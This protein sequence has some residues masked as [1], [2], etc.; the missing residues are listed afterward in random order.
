MRQIASIPGLSPDRYLVVD[1]HDTA[2]LCLQWLRD[3]IVD[4]RRRPCVETGGHARSRYRADLDAPGRRAR[5]RREAAAS[6]S[7]RGWPASAPRSPI[8]T[9]GGGFHNLSLATT[10]AHLVRAVLEGV[11]YNSRW[12]YEAVGAFVKRRL[13]PLRVIGGG[14]HRTC[15]ARSTPTSWTARSSGWPNPC[16]PTCG[17]RR[18]SPAWRSASV[19][20]EE[21]RALVAGRRASSPTQPTAA[22]YD[23]LYAE[24][25]RLYRAQK[26]MFARL[27]RR[28]AI[29]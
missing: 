29:T 1:N 26:P 20:A 14:A 12:L 18:C 10:R 8:A 21:I 17:G 24:F 19:D 23:R 2:G 7:P 27:N 11:A 4:A 25:P 13:D 16:T 5:G 22:V 6:C 15:G 28:S 3:N 9:P